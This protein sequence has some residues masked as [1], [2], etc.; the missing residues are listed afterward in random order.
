V[1]ALARKFGKRPQ[2]IFAAIMAIIGT[3]ICIA[4]G[5][6][7]NTLLSGRL[8]QGFGTTAFESLSMAV[9]GDL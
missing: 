5:D 2:F 6:S 4:S 3:S 1:S 8:I 7:Y 9:I